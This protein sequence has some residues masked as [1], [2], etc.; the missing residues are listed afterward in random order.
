MHLEIN[1]AQL[2]QSD[3]E[4]LQKHHCKISREAYA[5]DC[6]HLAGERRPLATTESAI[7][8]FFAIDLDDGTQILEINVKALRLSLLVVDIDLKLWNASPSPPREEG[9]SPAAV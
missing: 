9:E 2:S 6:V 8:E 4:I 3:I 1:V 7:T 5:I